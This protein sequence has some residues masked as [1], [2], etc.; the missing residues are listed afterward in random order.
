M[1]KSQ[2]AV[3]LFTG[4]FVDVSQSVRGPSTDLTLLKESGLLARLPDAV[5]RMF[6]LAYVGVEQFCPNTI[7]LLPRH[8]PRNQPRPPKDAIQNTMIA[9]CRT[10]VEHSEG[11]NLL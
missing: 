8:K 7:C 10:K 9:S 5:H 11:G 1:L 4:E 6:D 2:V 3:Y